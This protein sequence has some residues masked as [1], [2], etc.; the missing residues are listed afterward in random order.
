MDIRIGGLIDLDHLPRFQATCR[1]CGGTLLPVEWKLPGA[2]ALYRCACESCEANYWCDLPTDYALFGP[3]F[4]DARTNTVYGD[5]QFEWWKQW[6]QQTMELRHEVGSGVR[7]ERF[8]TL[9][10]PVILNCLERLYGH[11]LCKLFNAIHLLAQNPELDLV[12]VIPSA[13]RWLVPAGA[14][15]IIEV[16]WNFSK[17]A[18]WH[19]TIHTAISEFLSD[20]QTRY[21]VSCNPVLKVSADKFSELCGT[22]RFD[23]TTWSERLA[24][25]SVCFIWR[26]DRTWSAPQDEKLLN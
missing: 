25:P 11:S 19:E 17:G 21:L 2:R 20:F 9:H 26:D 24:S 1:A 13:L 3:C 15:A 22:P 16:D 12:V 14:S 23:R 6:L 5:T 10:A 18:Q 8:R 7:I 4:Y